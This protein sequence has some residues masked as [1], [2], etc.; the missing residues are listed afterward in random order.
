[1]RIGF[2]SYHKVC[3]IPKCPWR[4]LPCQVT[5]L[6]AEEVR[7]I[8]IPLSTSEASPREPQVYVFSGS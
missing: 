1:M 3:D 6:K 5:N 2:D 8:L 7:C 4:P